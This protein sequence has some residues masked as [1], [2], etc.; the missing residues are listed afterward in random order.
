MIAS[1]NPATDEL[2]QRFTPYE[3]NEIER[4]WAFKSDVLICKMSHSFCELT[5]NGMR[6]SSLWKWANPWLKQLGK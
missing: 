4:R 3:A 1:F 5:K 6:E 2:L